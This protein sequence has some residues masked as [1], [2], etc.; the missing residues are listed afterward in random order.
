MFLIFSSD[1]LRALRTSG[2]NKCSDAEI[3]VPVTK[4]QYVQFVDNPFEALKFRYW[5]GKLQPV[6]VLTTV[7]FMR[8]PHRSS[9]DVV[10]T[11]DA[12]EGLIKAKSNNNY[13][14]DVPVSLTLLEDGNPL[15]P[16]FSHQKLFVGHDAEFPL[17][18]KISSRTLSSFVPF[19]SQPLLDVSYGVVYREARYE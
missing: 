18:L 10:I 14:P 4:E 19:V 5:R 16:L 1:G 15:R 2:D 7:A 17:S 6:G 13:P 12:R 8:V 11:L 9:A 3:A